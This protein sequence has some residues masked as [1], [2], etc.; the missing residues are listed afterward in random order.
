MARTAPITLYHQTGDLVTSTIWNIGP[1]G[2]NDFFSNRPTFNGTCSLGTSVPDNTWTAIPF[3]SNAIDTDGGHNAATNSTRYTSQFSGWY[4][5]EGSVAFATTGGASRF[6]S[7]I[8]V[9]GS[10]WGG[11]SQFLYRQ[12]TD[13]TACNTS[14]LVHITLGSYVEIWCRQHTGGAVNLDT[15]NTLPSVSLFFVST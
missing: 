4:W 6:E 5:V 9:N 2:M 13:I 7:A 10:I 11:S 12:A 1:K 3:N 14:A 8:A 15:V